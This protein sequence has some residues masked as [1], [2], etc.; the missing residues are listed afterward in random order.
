M[1]EVL[2]MGMMKTLYEVGISLR[3]R[4][5]SSE[6]QPIYDA[7]HRSGFPDRV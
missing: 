2:V 3:K 6:S 5:G 7:S 1:L 4:T